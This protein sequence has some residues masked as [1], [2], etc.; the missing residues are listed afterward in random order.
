[1]S[2]GDTFLNGFNTTFGA[3]MQARD[4]KDRKKQREE[5]VE[6]RKA[7][8]KIEDEFRD[9]QIANRGME[10]VAQQ[11]LA[12]ERLRQEAARFAFE[13]ETNA[14]DFDFRRGQAADQNLA[15]LRAE[16]RAAA[17]D[18]SAEI[19]KAKLDP[20]REQILV[21]QARELQLRNAALA[22]P[23]PKPMQVV[24]RL[25]YDPEDPSAAPKRVITGPAGGL[26]AFTPAP[27]P[28]P[29]PAAAPTFGKE[30]EGKE[31][32]GPDGKRYIVKNGIPFLK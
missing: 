29:T 7:R 28:E 19:D 15:A 4:A 21:E 12:D 22:N 26:G 25:E 31:V 17:R 24:E 18:F 32:V 8:A 20:L 10:F 9:T 2:L 1:M 27:A 13:K 11:A 5:D 23:Q 3:G 6:F 30:L 16:G 14:R